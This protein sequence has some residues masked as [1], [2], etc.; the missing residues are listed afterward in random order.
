MAG[1]YIRRCAM[2]FP[3]IEKK[4]SFELRVQKPVKLKPVIQTEGKALS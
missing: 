3:I 4:K 2:D 1:T